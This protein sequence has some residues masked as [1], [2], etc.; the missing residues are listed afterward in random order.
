VL[1]AELAAADQEP[2]TGITGRFRSPVPVAELSLFTRR[3][4]TLT[5]A[6]VPLHEALTARRTLRAKGRSEV[7][8]RAIVRTAVA[9]RE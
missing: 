4:A 1:P 6:A 5:A 8:T 7:D 2:A 3:L 9:Q